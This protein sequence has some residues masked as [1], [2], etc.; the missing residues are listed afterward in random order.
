M[1]RF[2]SFLLI[3]IILGCRTETEPIDLKF[4]GDWETAEGPYVI[5]KSSSDLESQFKRGETGGFEFGVKNDPKPLTGNYSVNKNVAELTAQSQIL[6]DDA[7][8]ILKFENH[9]DSLKMI[10]IEIK[11][12]Q[13]SIL[14]DVKNNYAKTIR[15]DEIKEMKLT[16]SEAPSHLLVYYELT[17][18]VFK[19]N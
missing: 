17:K 8:T 6:G 19:K 1:I 4:A 2:Y 11:A 13:F 5:F 7:A 18:L 10:Y 3:L 16:D 9:I 15:G 12:K 14:I